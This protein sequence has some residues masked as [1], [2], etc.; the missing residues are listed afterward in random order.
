[1]CKSASRDVIRMDINLH[2]RCHFT[3]RIISVIRAIRVIEI[4]RAIR[5]IRVMGYGLSGLSGLLD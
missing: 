5:A 4:I 3:R 2:K 1:M